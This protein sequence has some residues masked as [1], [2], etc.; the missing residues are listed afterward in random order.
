M[1]A[2]PGFAGTAR[3]QYH[4]RQ[5]GVFTNMQPLNKP[6]VMIANAYEKFDAQGRLV[7]EG[8]RERIREL[9]AAPFSPAQGI[10]A[11]HGGVQTPTSD[12][13]LLS[14]FLFLSVA[15][16]LITEGTR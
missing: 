14:D 6:E 4:L 7:D 11:H 13:C 15:P 1:G 16:S 8:I 10:E 5:V 9:L 3:A 2:S 12:E